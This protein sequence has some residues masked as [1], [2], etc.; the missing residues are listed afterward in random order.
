MKIQTLI[1]TMNLADHKK[2][3]EAENVSTDSITINQVSGDRPSLPD[4]ITDGRHRLYSYAE[5]GLSK[6]RN[7]A[8]SV[9]DGDV[10]VIADDDMRY[11]DG[12][13]R[14]IEDAYI[15]NPQADVIAF[16]V[17]SDDPRQQK[18]IM[19]KGRLNRVMTMKIASWQITF[20]RKSLVDAGI[21]FDERFGAGTANYMGEENILLYD[22]VRKGL[23]VYYEPIKIATLKDDEPSTWFEGYNN[24]YF[25]AKGYVFRRMSKLLWPIYVLQFAVRK[26]SLYR[27]NMSLSMVL[28]LMIV[29]K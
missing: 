4:N 19:K 6:S 10:C 28:K 25:I 26:R 11:E 12:Y 23:A 1:S 8:L 29:S 20:K 17:D 27:D 24:K 9:S 18:K 3:I 15:R 5:R 7:H 21:S 13:G 22:C 14:I 2:I 16:H